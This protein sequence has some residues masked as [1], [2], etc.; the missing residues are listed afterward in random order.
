MVQERGLHSSGGFVP[1][2]G[3][4]TAEVRGWAG[5]PLETGWDPSWRQDSSG[6]VSYTAVRHQGA[7]F[8]TGNDLKLS[9]L[10]EFGW[11]VGG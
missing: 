7:S 2:Q 11:E 8:C 6:C 5:N 3:S 4:V 10:A 1:W 9:Y